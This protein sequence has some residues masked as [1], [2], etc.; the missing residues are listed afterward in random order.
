MQEFSTSSVPEN[1]PVHPASALNAESIAT[2]LA[3]FQN[4]LSAAIS[5]GGEDAQ[6]PAGPP[7][8]ASPPIDLHTLLEQFVAL[9]QEVTLQTKASRGQTRQSEEILEL[10]KQ[11]FTEL[12]QE[13]TQR[14]QLQEQQ[15]SRQEE[16]M[17]R[18]LWRTLVELHDV[19]SVSGREVQRGQQATLPLLDS[20]LQGIEN[21]C[22][23]ASPEAPAKRPGFWARLLGRRGPTADSPASPAEGQAALGQ[24]E[25]LRG[26]LMA[27]VTGYA[28][29]LERIERTLAQHG[30]EVIPTVGEPFDPELMEVVEAI[31][32]PERFSGEVAEEVRRGY[33]WRGRV[34]RFAQVR[35]VK[36][37]N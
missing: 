9:R 33:L 37:E 16:E 11:A 28:M 2:I 26:M 1:P 32:D 19:L 14:T 22:A 17:L 36:N 12:S 27:L 4:W 10:L 34:F 7:A 35:V 8:P 15:Q 29:S 23:G 20:L 3:D 18:P 21:R 5:P 6:G 24:G 30:L 13:R 31:P 25:K